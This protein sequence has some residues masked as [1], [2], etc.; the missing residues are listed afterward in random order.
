[1]MEEKREIM[2]HDQI[3]FWYHVTTNPTLSYRKNKIDNF[4][5]LFLD[6]RIAFYIHW[7]TRKDFNNFFHVFSDCWKF[8]NTLYIAKRH[9]GMFCMKV[10]NIYSS[11]WITWYE[12][13]K[14]MK[15]E[16]SVKI[17]HFCIAWCIENS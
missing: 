7:C 14:S 16:A 8:E 17:P 5:R 10:K 1:M 9:V 11:F 4:F 12:S 6:Q 2:Q 13:K 3:F 15:I